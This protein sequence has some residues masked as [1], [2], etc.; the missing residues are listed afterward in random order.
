[1]MKQLIALTSLP[2]ASIDTITFSHSSSI[3]MLKIFLKAIA[4]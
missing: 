1:M 4:I 2:K 3:T